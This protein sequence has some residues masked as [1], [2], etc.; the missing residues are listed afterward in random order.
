MATNLYSTCD[1]MFYTV[2]GIAKQSSAAFTTGVGNAFIGDADAE[3]HSRLAGQFSLPFNTTN[4]P[5][6]ITV[7]SRYLGAANAMIILPET[8]HITQERLKGLQTKAEELLTDIIAGKR[9]VLD[10]NGTIIVR[11]SDNDMKSNTEDYSPTFTHGDEM[12]MKTDPN[13]IED[14]EDGVF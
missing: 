9:E 11:L 1:S 5:P 12:G 2:C 6:I 8:L 14:E 10:V 4:P 13:R 3:I 7:I